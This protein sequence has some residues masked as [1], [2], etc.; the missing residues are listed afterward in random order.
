M[1]ASSS[2]EVSFGGIQGNSPPVLRSPEQCSE[3]GNGVCWLHQALVFLFPC[4]PP[5][6]SQLDGSVKS[7][8]QRRPFQCTEMLEELPLRE[9]SCILGSEYLQGQVQPLTGSRSRAGSI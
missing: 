9:A 1:L 3:V 6:S 2:N 7:F 4:V 8:E 5:L